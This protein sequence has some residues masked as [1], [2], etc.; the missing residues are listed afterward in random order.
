MDIQHERAARFK[1]LH[2]LYD[3][4]EANERAFGETLKIGS[5]LGFDEDLTQRVVQYLKGES[6][7]K[8]QAMGGI[9]VS[10]THWGIK[11]VEEALCYP[12][13]PTEHFPAFNITNN[14]TIGKMINSN[15]QQGGGNL[16]QNVN[17]A[18]VDKD[19]LLGLLEQIRGELDKSEIASS[20]KNNIEAD[21]DTTKAQL[22]KSEPIWE[23]V[24]SSL[25]SIKKGFEATTGGAIAKSAV[26]GIDKFL[27][28][29]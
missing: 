16:E 29:L 26:E 22:R 8:I 15:I 5:Q 18:E 25:Q 4:I 28:L 6:L 21:I 9:V 11:E 7:I 13:K 12:E 23:V 27:S 10:I 19:A 20:D 14:I 3:E 24:K 17:T 1:F 2:K